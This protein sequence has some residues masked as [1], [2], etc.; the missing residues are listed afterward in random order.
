MVQ[1]FKRSWWAK[2]YQRHAQNIYNRCDTCQIHAPSSPHAVYQH[3]PGPDDPF[4]L[5]F[6]YISLNK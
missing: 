6:G 4:W 2:G 3:A 1:A 5:Q